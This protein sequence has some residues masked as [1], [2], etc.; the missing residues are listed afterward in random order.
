MIHAQPSRGTSSRRDKAIVAERM[1]EM[2]VLV[3]NPGERPVV[4]EI[5]NTLEAKQIIVGGLIEMV[6]PANHIDDAVLICNDE[7]KL[8]NMEPNRVL[9]MADGTAYDIICGPMIVI[10]A[11][12]DSDDFESLTDSQID[13]YSQLYA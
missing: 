8:L 3:I 5:K 6:V 7:G 9:R 2:R 13:Y 12:F 11:P 1:V 10:R 4:A